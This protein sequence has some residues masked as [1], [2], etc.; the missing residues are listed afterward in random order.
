MGLGNGPGID[1]SVLSQG[2]GLTGRDQHR[3]WQ[4]GGEKAEGSMVHGEGG[5]LGRLF[6]FAVGTNETRTLLGES[7]FQADPGKAFDVTIDE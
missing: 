6:R 5:T 7:G 2:A 1:M 4:R 3:Q